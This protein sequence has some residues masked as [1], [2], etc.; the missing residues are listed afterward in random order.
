MPD[1]YRYCACASWA[2]FLQAAVEIVEANTAEKYV[3]AKVGSEWDDA[4]FC[5]RK[6]SKLRVQ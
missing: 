3:A 4:T 1:P 6:V 2:W 5:G